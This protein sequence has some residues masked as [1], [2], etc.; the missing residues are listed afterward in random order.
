V[1]YI[2][3]YLFIL[4]ILAPHTHTHKFFQSQKR[5][6]I[7]TGTL[8]P[9]RGQRTDGWYKSDHKYIII[10]RYDDEDEADDED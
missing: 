9:Y 6:I 4:V 1:L 3:V 2:R 10:E 8:F 5:V 7:K